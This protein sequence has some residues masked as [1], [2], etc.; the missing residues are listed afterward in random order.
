M[1]NA[2]SFILLILCTQI[3]FAQTARDEQ[4]IHDLVQT[5]AD[6]WTEGSGE[7]FASVFA[8]EH[9]FIVW[10]GLYLKNI[11]PDMNAKSHQGIFNSI[12]KDTE[13]YATVDKIR[14][15]REDLALVHVLA[16]VT[17]KGEARPEHPDVLWSGL[18]EKKAG[19]WK[20]LSFHNLDLEVFQDEQ[21]RQQFPMP[22]EVVYA[23][24]YTEAK[25]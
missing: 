18:L 19:G 3:T 16:A 17:K 22:P 24:W 14:F 7:K 21:L 15:I 9:D 1:K 25:K 20:I 5:M 10:N 6:G 8:D 23:S 12:Y 11:N 4:A 2:I 13:H